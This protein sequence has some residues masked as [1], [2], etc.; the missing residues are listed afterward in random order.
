MRSSS[1]KSNCHRR[2]NRRPVGS[3]VG[4]SG[5]G[6]YALSS[7]LLE[8]FLPSDEPMPKRFTPAVHPMLKE[9]SNFH[10][11][12]RN[13]SDVF[14]LQAV[15]SSDGG[16]HPGAELHRRFDRRLYFCTV[17]SSDATL[18]RESRYHNRWRPT[19]IPNPNL[20]SRRRSRP[21]AADSPVRRHPA[22]L[23]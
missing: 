8:N 11:P 9:F 22:H 19:C 16:F 21:Y 23:R 5:E 12:V 1:T 15:G 10:R 13:C 7:S 6:V 20:P 17:G 18:R 4:S 2:M 3:S 14:I